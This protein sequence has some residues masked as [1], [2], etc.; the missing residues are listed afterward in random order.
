MRLTK[1]IS[2][3]MAVV[4]MLAAMPVSLF[5]VP[6]SSRAAT[7]FFNGGDIELKSGE[8][9]NHIWMYEGASGKF[10]S[11]L[12]ITGY[13]VE[14][15]DI[16]SVNDKGKYTAKGKGVTDLTVELDSEDEES[17]AMFKLHVVEY[18]E[19]LKIS[20]RSKTETKPTQDVSS[21][22]TTQF[23]IKGVDITEDAK[24]EF[25]VKEGNMNPSFT[26]SKDVVTVSS[27]RGGEC[28]V[29]VSVNGVETT[30][31]W[32]LNAIRA[33]PMVLSPGKS[34]TVSISNARPSAFEWTSED[35]SIAT[36][37]SGGKITAKKEGNVVISGTNKNDDYKVGCVVSVTSEEK[38]KAITRAVEI[39]GG[40]YSQG[41]R[42]LAGYYDCSSLVWRAYSPYGYNF[43][44]RSGYAPTAASEAAYLESKGN[45]YTTWKEKDMQKMR[46]Q[47]GDLMFRTNTGNGRYK[48]INHV[49]MITGYDV[50]SFDK[51]G[52][53]IL[54]C[55]W[56]SKNP[57][58]S[59]SI[60]EHDIIG[61]V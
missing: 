33:E 25:S 9:T 51:K 58:Y 15:G 36:I 28:V 29:A 26:R 4:V 30:F 8:S 27:S 18:P 1:R 50:V 52:K 56:A 38:V 49:E 37:S 41:K 54:L 19:N 55:D 43:G 44:V 14:D 60:Y 12:D 34:K 11:E 59:L 22:P 57:E 53:P 20:P 61:K 47:A 21:A 35:K 3:L 24:V 5:G 39:G 10:T 17:F 13:D 31:K 42:M 16:V 32:V 46:Y 40:T 45:V 7:T 6:V 48:G 2:I 23:K